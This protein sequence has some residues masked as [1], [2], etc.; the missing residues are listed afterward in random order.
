MVNKKCKKNTVQRLEIDTDST[1]DSV[2]VFSFCNVAYSAP[3]TPEAITP[4][5]FR[6]EMN[7]FDG[8]F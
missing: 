8:A 7:E 2:T 3:R 5:S 4:S 6:K 1:V